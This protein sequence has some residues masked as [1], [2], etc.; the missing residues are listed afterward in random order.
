MAHTHV[1]LQFL[2]NGICRQI[3]S[4]IVKLQREQHEEVLYTHDG[5][6]IPLNDLLS[7]NGQSWN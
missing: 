5:I 7:I 1:I 6:R 3:Q 4:R 2:E